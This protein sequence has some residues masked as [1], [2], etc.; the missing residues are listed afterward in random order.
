MYEGGRWEQMCNSYQWKTKFLSFIVNRKGLKERLK[1]EIL[2]RDKLWDSKHI[3][4]FLGG[5]IN[6]SSGMQKKVQSQVRGREVNGLAHIGP[7]KWERGKGLKQRNWEK[8]VECQGEEEDYRA[9]GRWNKPRR[10][11][12]KKLLV[13]KESK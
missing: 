5:W 6:E 7:K 4:L 3:A 9:E 2:C 10:W 11:V 8:R 13:V 1:C 12:S